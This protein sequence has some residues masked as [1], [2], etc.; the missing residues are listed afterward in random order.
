[1]KKSIL[2][3]TVLSTALNINSTMATDLVQSNDGVD[4]QGYESV[5]M[6]MIRILEIPDSVLRDEIEWAL[7]HL[8][9]INNK[10]KL[11]E[12]LY[13]IDDLGVTISALKESVVVLE[14]KYPVISFKIKLKIIQE[15]LKRGVFVIDGEERA[16]FEVGQIAFNKSIVSRLEEQSDFSDVPA[17]DGSICI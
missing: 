4:L 6:N 5:Y 13:G 7:N 1:M 12:K 11:S 16:S 9:F 10:I 2:T 8:V 17:G 15:L 14:E 3:L